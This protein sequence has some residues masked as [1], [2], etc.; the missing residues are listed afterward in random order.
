VETALVVPVIL[1]LLMGMVELGR[2][3]NAYMAVTH[4]GRHGARYAA[5][6]GTNEEVTTRVKNAATPLDTSKV[7]VVIDP[8]TGRISGQDVRITVTYPVQMLTPLAGLF[9]NPVVVRSDVTMRLE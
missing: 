3:S 8:A 2:V 7:N 1:L 9:K 6:G 5:I 4:A